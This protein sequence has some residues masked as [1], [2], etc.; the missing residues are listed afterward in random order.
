VAFLAAGAAMT[1]C[2]DA[3]DG[4]TPATTGLPNP[5][6]IFCIESGGRY[7]I[8]RAADGAQ[9][10]VCILADGTEADAWTYFREKAAPRVKDKP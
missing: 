5:A 4:E 9:T 10:G 1:G 7:E 8:R 3:T 6:A 2:V